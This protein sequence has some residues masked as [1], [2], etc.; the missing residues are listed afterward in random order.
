MPSDDANRTWIGEASFS[1][2][3]VSNNTVWLIGYLR[4]PIN[5]TYTFRLDSNANSSLFLSSDENPANKIQIANSTLPQSNGI[6]LQ[7]NT[8]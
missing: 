2:Q 4:S 3:S 5:A 8:K 7:K 1:S 6:F